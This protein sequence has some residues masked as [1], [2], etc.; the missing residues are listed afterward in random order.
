MSTQQLLQKIKKELSIFADTARAKHAQ[1]FFKTAPGEY[2]EGDVFIGVRVPQI[3]T[4]ARKY[5]NTPIS[6]IEM[7]IIS[8]I[9]E[10]RMLALVLMVNQYKKADNQKQKVLYNLYLSHTKYINNWDLVDISAP[11]I[12]GAYVFE[13]KKGAVLKRLTKSNTLWERRIA[14]IACFYHIRQ[15]AFDEPLMIAESLLYDSHD[16]MHKAVGWMLREVGKRDEAL[17]EHFLQTHNYALLPRTLLRYA[18]ER[19]PEQKRKEYL[20][21]TR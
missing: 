6:V 16:L 11:H 9:H 4:I 18:I 13:Y 20:Q 12:V 7:L 5:K 1:K 17:L 8:P 3:R 14:M 21:G 19:L 15:N 10:E 2:G